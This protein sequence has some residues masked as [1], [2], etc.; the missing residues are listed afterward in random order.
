M[1]QRLPQTSV[2]PRSLFNACVQVSPK[3]PPPWSLACTGSVLGLTELCA[4]ER[5]YVVGPR[6]NIQWSMGEWSGSLW[7]KVERGRGLT[8]RF[9]CPQNTTTATFNNN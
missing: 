4:Y 5:A 7:R 9:S 1:K 3:E 6:A 8:V 2:G